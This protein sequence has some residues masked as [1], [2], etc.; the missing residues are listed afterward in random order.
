[1]WR[2]SSLNFPLGSV[3]QSSQSLKPISALHLSHFISGRPSGS[4]RMS[5]QLIIV[6]SSPCEDH[7]GESWSGQHLDMKKMMMMAVAWEH[8]GTEFLS[9]TRLT[10]EA[11]CT[12]IGSNFDNTYHTNTKGAQ[13]NGAIPP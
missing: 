2:L 3:L 13:T 8:G 12:I 4:C 6:S 10:I 7:D 1:M 5:K 11:L 9:N